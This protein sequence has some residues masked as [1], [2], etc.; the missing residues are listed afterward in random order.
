MVNVFQDADWVWHDDCK[1]E[2]SYVNFYDEIYAKSDSVYKMYISAD[3]QY[4]VYINNKYIPSTQYSDYEDYKIFDEID[5]TEYLIQ[6]K[7]ILKII[8]YYQGTDSSTYRKFDCGLIYKVTENDNALICSGKNTLTAPNANYI[9]DTCPWISGQLGYSFMYNANSEENKKKPADIQ[10]KKAF[11]YKRPVKKLSVKERKKSVLIAQG[12]FKDCKDSEYSDRD[13]GKRIQYSF[14]AFR[15]VHDLI[16]QGSYN[17]ILPSTDGLDI[18]TEEESDGVYLI[19]DLGEE[20]TG[21]LDLELI[22]PENCEI[23]VGYSE[24]LDDLRCRSYV[25]G[26][27]FAAKYIS[28]NGLNRYT[29]PFRRFGLRYMQVHV[30]AKEFKLFYAGIRPVEYPVSDI[31]YFMCSDNLHNKIYDVCVHTLHMCMH[32]HYEDCP[33]REQAL[34]TMDSRNQMLCGYYT[35]GEFDFAKSSLRLMGHSIRED[36]MLELCSPARVVITIPAFSAIYLIQLYEYLLYSGD[37]DFIA[38]MLPVAERIANEFIRRIEPRIGLLKVFREGIYWNF[39]EW[40]TGFSGSIGYENKEED[41]TYDA[42]LNAFVSIGLRSMSEIFSILGNMGKSDFYKKT[43]LRLNKQI[44]KIFWNEEKQ[45]YTS[46]YLDKQKPH[47]AELTQSLI[48][49]AGACRDDKLDNVLEAL[50]NGELIPITP[51]HAVF[52]YEA[53]MQKSDTYAKF[54]FD[55][56]SSVWGEMLYKNATTFWETRAGGIDFGKAGSLCHGWSATPAYLYFKYALGADYSNFFSESKLNPVK[57]GLYEVKG[58]ILSAEGKVYN[59]N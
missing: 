24:H 22:L 36:N 25:Y 1:K 32:E 19:F 35:F 14:Q 2:N 16:I 59:L 5:I 29:N 11:L 48:V 28:A 13:L 39:Y 34:Y 27:N 23:V 38:E 45:L 33:M 37:K 54:V 12:I 53:L 3:S 41:M 6:G 57:S 8:A 20:C 55:D 10:N 21:F 18:K 31:P 42:P 50:K 52:K 56:I 15:E 7:N 30:Y 47:Y 43:Y 49:Y 26:R 58:R 51:S 40:Q 46:F 4:A 44:D 9:S 17:Q